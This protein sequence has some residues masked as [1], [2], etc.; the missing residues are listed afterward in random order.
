MN[1]RYNRSARLPVKN[2]RT[3]EERGIENC[4]MIENQKLIDE[5]MIKTKQYE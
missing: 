3:E 5:G 1:N 4:N 2:H